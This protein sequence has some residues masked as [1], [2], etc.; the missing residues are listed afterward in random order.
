MGALKAW[1]FI[2]DWFKYSDFSSASASIA[3]G[4][5]SDWK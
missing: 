1:K 5:P 3:V 2:V 4:T